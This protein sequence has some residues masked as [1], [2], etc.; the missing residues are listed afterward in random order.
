MT[1]NGKAHRDG[2]WSHFQIGCREPIVMPQVM[3]IKILLV[4]VRLVTIDRRCALYETFLACETGLKIEPSS[5]DKRKPVH[6]FNQ[7]SNWDTKKVAL[8]HCS[9]IKVFCPKIQFTMRN[10]VSSQF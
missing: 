8:S 2:G 1:G 10:L 7:N 9:K 6:S 5:K 4:V 3:L